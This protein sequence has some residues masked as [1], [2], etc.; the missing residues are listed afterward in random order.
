MGLGGGADHAWHGAQRN[1]E[2]VFH[3]RIFDATKKYGTTFQSNCGN[4]TARN[5]CLPIL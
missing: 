1:V 2:P 3:A 4:S 5:C